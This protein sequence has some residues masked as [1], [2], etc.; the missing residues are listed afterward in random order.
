MATV[1]NYPEMHREIEN[2]IQAEYISFLGKYRVKSKNEIE[3]K[4]GI[5]FDSIIGEYGANNVKNK[6]KEWFKYYLTPKAFKRL[7]NTEKI[8][9]NTLLD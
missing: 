8:I 1:I 5:T 4:Q 3:I 2:N 6:H 7:Q 9:L